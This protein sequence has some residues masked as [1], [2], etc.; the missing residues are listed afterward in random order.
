MFWK[1]AVLASNRSD[2]RSV[3]AASASKAARSGTAA[4]SKVGR[5][6]TAVRR[7]SLAM[8]RSATWAALRSAVAARSVRAAI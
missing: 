1:R 4:G 8:A 3:R 6:S 2:N 5:P 7:R